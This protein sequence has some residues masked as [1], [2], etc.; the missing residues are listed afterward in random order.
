MVTS[1]G[2]KCVYMTCPKKEYLQKQNVKSG[3]LRLEVA[4]GS[5][6]KLACGIF[7]GETEMF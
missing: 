6:C 2:D 1:Y 4:K 3:C 5:V 7:W